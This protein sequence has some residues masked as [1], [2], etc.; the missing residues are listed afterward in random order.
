MLKLFNENPNCRSRTTKIICELQ[1]LSN[2]VIKY[3]IGSGWRDCF[4]FQSAYVILKADIRDQISSIS[5]LERPL[6]RLS[7]LHMWERK[8]PQK[9]NFTQFFV[10]LS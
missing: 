7:N 4:R 6:L 10:F 5:Q 8:Y 2:K 3:M 9:N 1:N